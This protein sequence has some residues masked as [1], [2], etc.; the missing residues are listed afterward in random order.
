M[1]VL[2]TLWNRDN[3]WLF[4]SKISPK[5][6]FC[7][8]IVEFTGSKLWTR[9]H[10]SWLLPDPLVSPWL[11]L[12]WS[13]VFSSLFL[14]SF[15]K[16]QLLTSH[17]LWWC[18]SFMATN[19]GAAFIVA[20]IYDEGPKGMNLINCFSGLVIRSLGY[21]ILPSIL[22]WYRPSWVSSI[23]KT[24]PGWESQLSPLK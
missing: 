11:L 14:G 23:W 15:P 21:G 19:F 16:G 18:D 2:M 5:T 9:L 1:P 3:L 13:C 12:F 8:A 24:Y 17:Q 10:F 22:H 4:F 7:V 20:G 6:H